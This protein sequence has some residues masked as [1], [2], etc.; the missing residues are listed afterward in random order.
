MCVCNNNAKKYATFHRPYCFTEILNETN[1]WGPL[2]LIGSL[3]QNP[4]GN[5]SVLAVKILILHNTQVH[6]SYCQGWKKHP[7]CLLWGKAAEGLSCGPLFF[8]L[9]ASGGLRNNFSGDKFLPS[10]QERKKIDVNA[11][12]KYFSHPI[13]R[14]VCG[15]TLLWVP[16]T[17]LFY[18]V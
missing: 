16:Q 11:P 6:E 5:A 8:I 10:T 2:G 9:N 1:N 3:Q 4:A 15:R 7:A 18:T 13:L 14:I 12:F 17:M